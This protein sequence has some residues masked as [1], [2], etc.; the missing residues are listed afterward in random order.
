MFHSY[1]I[2]Q[3]ACLKVTHLYPEVREKIIYQIHTYLVDEEGNAG[4][5]RWRLACRFEEEDEYPIAPTG[6]F[7]LCSNSLLKSS[8]SSAITILHTTLSIPIMI[9][10]Y[11]QNYGRGKSKLNY[12]PFLPICK[13]TWVRLHV[14]VGVCELVCTC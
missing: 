10:L 9:K 3:R 5:S 6:C 14:I 13:Y 12:N 8:A 2:Q 7:V 11:S 1:H 4:S